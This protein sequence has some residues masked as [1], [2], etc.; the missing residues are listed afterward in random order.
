M[1]YT[2][3]KKF[4]NWYDKNR[5]S[6][7]KFR[8]VHKW[9]NSWKKY[10]IAYMIENDK[11]FFY[12][13]FSFTNSIQEEGTHFTRP[14]YD[15]SV[16]SSTPNKKKFDFINYN[17]EFSYDVFFMPNKKKITIENQDFVVDFDFFSKESLTLKNILSHSM[18]QKDL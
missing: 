9:N 3:W 10:F 18:S 16:S 13:F 15:F 2:M 7:I 8:E 6:K 5:Y 14:S 4:R 12:P 17:S 1:N 11:Y